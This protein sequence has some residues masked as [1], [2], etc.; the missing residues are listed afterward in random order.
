MTASSARTRRIACCSIAARAAGASGADCTARTTDSA[1]ASH[2]SHSPR[3]CVIA[4]ST[5]AAVPATRDRGTIR[6]ISATRSTRAGR[7]T[8]SD[9]P[10][11]A[12]LASDAARPHGQGA[13]RTLASVTRHSRAAAPAA[14]PVHA[15]RGC[16]ASTAPRATRAAVTAGLSG[17]GRIA[18]VRTRPARATGAAISTG[19]TRSAS[20]YRT[21]GTSAG[22]TRAARTTS[23]ARARSAAGTSTA[24]RE[25]GR[26]SDQTGRP[27]FPLAA[28][29]AVA[30]RT[31]SASCTAK[32]GGCSTT[33][34]AN[35]TV[36]T[37]GPGRTIEDHPIRT[38]C[39]IGAVTA[40]ATRAA[41]A[42]RA[43]SPARAAIAAGA[44]RRRRVIAVA[45]V[46][47][48][49]AAA[50]SWTD[51]ERQRYGAPRARRPVDYSFARCTGW[52][53]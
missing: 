26:A 30:A 7:A 18:A 37:T 48:V 46:A 35:A 23:T 6:S 17:Y 3:G 36:P 29:P 14:G 24:A 25:S 21:C 28:I 20:T 5:G 22:R 40:R 41:R 27:V 43:S 13:G 32:T 33:G 8:S 34:T 39:P 16:I 42:A 51:V 47:T 9:G 15:A 45:T 38:S 1:G 11:I 19:A 53:G 10:R 4:S 50:A 31:A 2:D 49:A 12:T 44:S 52:T